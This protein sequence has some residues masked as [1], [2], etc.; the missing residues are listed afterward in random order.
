MS[1]DI[2]GN[3]LLSTQ[4]GENQMVDLMATSS[5]ISKDIVDTLAE[6]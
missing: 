5:L 4:S 1:A 2:N 6:I 3:V